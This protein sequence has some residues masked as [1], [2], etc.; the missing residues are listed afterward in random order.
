M[1]EKGL[2]L[3]NMI[4]EKIDFKGACILNELLSR[5]QPHINHEEKLMVE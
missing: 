3:D 5:A 1:F 2:R 4:R